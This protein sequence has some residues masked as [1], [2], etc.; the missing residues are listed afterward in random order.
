MSATTTI[1]LPPA[2]RARLAV[3]AEQ[4]G[5]SVHGLIVEAI[6]RHAE[7]EEQLR[8]LV[9]DAHAA[10]AQIDRVGEIYSHAD[11]RAWVDRLAAEPD[12]PLPPPCR[13]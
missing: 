7:Y 9:Q 4:T 11:V 6:E 8:R 1:R 5:R 2:L 10:D 13:R 12:A 3:I